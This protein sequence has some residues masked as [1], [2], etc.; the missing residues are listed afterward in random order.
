MAEWIRPSAAS[1]EPA[2]DVGSSPPYAPFSLPGIDTE[3][4]LKVARGRIELY[5]RLLRRFRESELDFGDRFRAALADADLE[6]ATRHAHSLKGVAGNI[7]AH[8]VRDAAAELETACA[9]ADGADGIE[10]LLATTIDR[11]DLVCSGLDALGVPAA[12]PVREALAEEP[13]EAPSAAPPAPL[14]TLEELHALLEEGNAD[15]VELAHVIAQHPFGLAHAELTSVMLHQVEAYDF[16]AA[17]DTLK[18]W[19]DGPAG[20]RT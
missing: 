10:L 17:L 4:G 6:T 9:D 16:D 8:D 15:A 18:Q 13:S 11:L 12:E 19:R 5:H 2:R 14:D 1:A 3:A 7:G 20:W